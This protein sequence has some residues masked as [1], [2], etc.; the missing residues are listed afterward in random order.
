MLSLF[1]ILFAAAIVAADQ[2]TKS[3][4]AAHLAE[5]TVVLIPGHLALHCVKNTGMAL[6]LLSGAR[7]LFVAVGLVFLA[8]GIW[9]LAKSKLSKPLERWCVVAILGGA[10][11]NLID[12]VVSGAVV[13]MISVPWFSTFNVADIFITVPAVILVVYIL[14]FDRELLADKPKTAEEPDH[15]THT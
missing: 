2:I 12:R 11:G 3:L 15:D 9:L 10:A 5:K 4:A 7:W 6:S 1:Y 14:F 13:D 8:G